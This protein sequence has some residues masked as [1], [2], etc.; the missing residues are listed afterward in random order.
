MPIEERKNILE[1]NYVQLFVGRKH[2]QVWQI[3]KKEILIILTVENID[4]QP[5]SQHK[6]DYSDLSKS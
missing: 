5:H 3:S 6:T 2:I 4:H 1:S